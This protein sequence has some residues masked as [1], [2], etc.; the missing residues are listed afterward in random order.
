[1]LKKIN[2]V[3]TQEQESKVIDLFKEAR[4]QLGFL[5]NLN[6][7]DRIRMAKLSRGRVDFVD[8]AVVEARAN[9]VY[10]PAYLTLEEFIADVELKDSLHR[11]RA[12]AQ[13]LTE[14]IDDTLLLTET[15]AYRKSRLFY[16][17]LKAAGRAGEEDAERV[18]KD[19]AYHFKGQGP[20]KVPDNNDGGSQEQEQTVLTDKQKEINT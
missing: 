1:M 12:E 7:I 6:S 4:S 3:I 16:N 5:V 8:T 15:E 18:A 14:R 20:S 17:S 2:E 9:P 10:L 13:S 19:L 11:I